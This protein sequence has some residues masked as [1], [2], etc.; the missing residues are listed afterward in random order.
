[1]YAVEVLINV[2]D[3]DSS[4]KDGWCSNSTNLAPKSVQ[5]TDDFVM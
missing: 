3:I 5:I 2:G 4:R 1:M